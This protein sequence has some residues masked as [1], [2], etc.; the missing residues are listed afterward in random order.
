MT[1]K[2][3]SSTRFG[4]RPSSS[5]MRVNS[6]GV[7][8]CVERISGVI[9]FTS[10]QL[11]VSREQSRKTAH[12]SL[13]TAHFFINRGAQLVRLDLAKVSEDDLAVFVVKKGRRQL[14]VPAGVH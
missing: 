8:L 9:I 5:F 11:A 1:E 2:T 3:P 12:C 14:A 6:S 4:S 10:K 13:L 7:R